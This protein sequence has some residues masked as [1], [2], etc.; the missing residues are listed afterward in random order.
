[1]AELLVAGVI[2]ST[3]LLGVYEMFRQTLGIEH[4]VNVPTTD[5]AAARAL[6][7]H[8][9]E[10]LMTTVVVPPL[11]SV[12]CH[13]DKTNGEYELTCLVGPSG[14]HPQQADHAALQ[15]RRYRWGFAREDARAGTVR[16]QT[17]FYAGTANITPGASRGDI[18]DEARWAQR[19]AAVVARRIDRMD[20]R[21]LPASEFNAPQA[22]WKSAWDAPV[23]R[24]AI[25]I[26]VQVGDQVVE[27][28]I[29]PEVTG[30]LAEAR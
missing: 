13:R 5:R 4:G 2:V 6:A 23:G 28:L 20:I 29:V 25:S 24:V 12:E 3:V 21:F 15:M 22:Q 19:P 1:M 14:V 7:D 16:M 18:E 27:R 10:A 26:K 9:E 30:A 11:T 8:L 17:L